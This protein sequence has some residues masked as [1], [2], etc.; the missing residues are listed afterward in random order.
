MDKNADALAMPLGN[1]DVVH[2]SATRTS[3]FRLG[4]QL[5]TLAEAIVAPNFGVNLLSIGVSTSRGLKFW[6]E[7]DRCEIY[8]ALEQLPRGEKLCTVAKTTTFI[9][10]LELNLDFYP[11]KQTMHQENRRQHWSDSING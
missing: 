10:C 5:A 2:S 11:F 7:R 3:F 6:F 8:N 9:D 1:N 4:S